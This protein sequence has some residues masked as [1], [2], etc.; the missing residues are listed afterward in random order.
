[1]KINLFNVS[2]FGK[3]KFSVNEHIDQY[4][5]SQ[6]SN[7]RITKISF[8]GIKMSDDYGGTTAYRAAF[9]IDAIDLS[10]YRANLSQ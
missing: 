9:E 10:E 7:C 2:V 8:E 6:W 1:M 4:K 5:A 3:K